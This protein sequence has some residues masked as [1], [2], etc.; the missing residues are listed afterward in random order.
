MGKVKE[1]VAEEEEGAAAFCMQLQ[2][3]E[4]VAGQQRARV[5]RHEKREGQRARARLRA[6]ISEG[7]SREEGDMAMIDH[8]CRQGW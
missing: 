8:D 5:K 1:T 6:P 7:Q 4:F 3:L 2:A